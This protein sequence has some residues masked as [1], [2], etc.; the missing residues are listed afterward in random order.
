MEVVP[1]LLP[2]LILFLVFVLWPLAQG[3]RVSFYEWSIMPGAEQT[4]V[5]LANF[6]RAFQDPVAL[7]AVK[8]SLLYVIV[9]VPGQMFFGMLAALAL[10]Q[11]IAGRTFWR[12]VYYLPVLTSWVVVSFIFKYL[13]NGGGAP[14]N[15]ILKDV[16]HILPS[17][18]DWLQH[19]WTAEIAIMTLGIWKGIGWNMVMFLAGLQGIPRE[20]YEAAAIDGATRTQ[21]FWRVTMP[22][23]R[24]V[25]L[26]VMVLLT[27]GGFGVFLSVVLLTG[28][29]PM[30]QTQVILSYIYDNG[31]KYFDFGY[32]FALATLLSLVILTFNLLQIRLFGAKVDR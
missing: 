12:A 4:F 31:F 17:Y 5:G 20:L 19:Y 9:T 13:F 14:I 2:G 25:L 10:N 23:M 22:L 6:K 3:V 27:I 28:G 26:Y 7:T 16:L 29:G 30:N 18:L 1:F 11:A 8:N 21:S 32:G 24:P 15:Y